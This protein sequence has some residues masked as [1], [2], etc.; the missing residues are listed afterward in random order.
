MNL[1]WQGKLSR[2][3][4]REVEI[5]VME[6]TVTI[7][8]KDVV[9]LVGTV[10]RGEE[11]AD[12]TTISTW[13]LSHNQMTDS[14]FR[15]VVKQT[16]GVFS[17]SVT[18]INL[19]YNY[20]SSEIIGELALWLDRF[21]NATVDLRSNSMENGDLQYCNKLKGRV[22]IQRDVD[23]DI[24]TLRDQITEHSRTVKEKIQN[25]TQE[26]MGKVLEESIIPVIQK[27]LES[28]Q[29]PHQMVVNR[30][31]TYKP[32]RELRAVS[33]RKKNKEIVFEYDGLFVVRTKDTEEVCLLNNASQLHL[34]RRKLE[35]IKEA[36][37]AISCTMMP[38]W[39]QDTETTPLRDRCPMALEDLITCPKSPRLSLL[40][41]F[42]TIEEGLDVREESPLMETEFVQLDILGIDD[43]HQIL[44]AAIDRL[45]E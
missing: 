34:T 38:A 4:L 37:L 32:R 35:K 44:S 18:C 24:C 10:W 2:F 6:N 22:I 17:E 21:P 23:R 30:D 45:L 25:Y 19:S 39:K 15:Y 11:K 7:K 13:N 28:K 20:L 41:T 1:D 27:H 12:L 40:V 3:L 42:F 5:E 8:G 16:E 36:L 26:N 29:Y 14:A 43:N 31:P 33:L 9:D